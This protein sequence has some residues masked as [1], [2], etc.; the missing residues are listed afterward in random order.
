[1]SDRP[2]N[3]LQASI[4]LLFLLLVDLAF[5]SFSGW[6]FGKLPE[7]EGAAAAAEEGR[8]GR[9]EQRQRCDA[10]AHANAMP[11]LPPVEKKKKR[12]YG[13]WLQLGGGDVGVVLVDVSG[14]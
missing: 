8:E 10:D 5:P 11:M 1:M 4:V 6:R 9:R 2:I 7:N 14:A 12:V 13:R 3:Q